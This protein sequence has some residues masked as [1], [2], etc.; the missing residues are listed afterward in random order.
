MTFDAFESTSFDTQ[1]FDLNRRLETL[2]GAFES[3]LTPKDGVYANAAG[4]SFDVA[5]WA[6]INPTEQVIAL[7]TV[8]LHL[9]DI[10][11]GLYNGSDLGNGQT[12]LGLKEISERVRNNKDN[13][14]YKQILKQQSGFTAEVLGTAKEN[15]RAK[16]EGTGITTYRAD[17]RPDMFPRNDQ[18]VD[19][20][21]VD[22]EGNILERVQVKFVGSDA[23]SCLD[24][25]M[26]KKFDKYYNDGMVD[27]ME[28]PKDYYDGVKRLIPERIQ[29][30]ERQLARVEELGKTEVAEGIKTRIDRL[31]KIDSMLEQSTV[32][33]TE[34]LG[35]T[36]HERRY[37][38]KFFA[39]NSFEKSHLAGKE[40][41]KIAATISAAVS[42]IDNA[43]KVMNGELSIQ[44]A[45]I[46][47]AEDTGAAGAVAYGTAFIST[48]VSQAMS[49]SSHQLISSLG[50]AGVPGVAVSFGI[51]SFDSIVDFS[52]GTIDASQLADDLME[53]AAEIGGSAAG[54]A[55]AG[56]ALGSVVPGAGTLAG[57]GAGLVGGMIGCAAASEAYVSLK[58]IGFEGADALS[59]KAQEL[60]NSTV[61]MAK[62]TVP[63]HVG[64]VVSAINTFAKT[65]SLPFR[66]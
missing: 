55:L 32:S 59:G 5:R 65:N 66:V 64:E 51:Q 52:N 19:K 36:K 60:A 40:G 13:P 8:G 43:S 2:H 9:F 62:E 1:A 22:G 24:R 39:E 10:A 61:E 30:L 58:E 41:A 31:N 16:A 15:V 20:I 23:K 18:Y 4:R 17:D 29:K 35:A 46:D 6:S 42:T 50:H 12:S 54:M 14:Y 57:F 11:K 47:V 53:N 28:I 56:A 3:R 25:L 48:S 63:R 26:S 21:R 38:G 27:K 49:G 7:D 45:F 44:E 34:A 33:S 37:V